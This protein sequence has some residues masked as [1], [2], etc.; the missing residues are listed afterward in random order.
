MMVPELNMRCLYVSIANLISSVTSSY[1]FFSFSPYKP[2][3]DWPTAEFVATFSF[4]STKVLDIK[5]ETKTIQH[6]GSGSS[7]KIHS[8]EQG[9][10]QHGGGESTGSSRVTSQFAIVI[11]NL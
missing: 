6:L 11:K 10:D 8:E 2:I 1:F 7:F 4:L 9:G 5:V 3:S